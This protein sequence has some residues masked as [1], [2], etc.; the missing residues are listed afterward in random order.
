VN[1]AKKLPAGRAPIQA[2]NVVRELCD[3]LDAAKRGD[4]SYAGSEIRRAVT[5][6]AKL[7]STGAI[8]SHGASLIRSA[9]A[10]A[11]VAMRAVRSGAQVPAA[12]PEL[13]ESQRRIM[14]STMGIALPPDQLRRSEDEP[15]DS[16]LA[17]R[18][19]SARTDFDGEL[20]AEYHGQEF[21]IKRTGAR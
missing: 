21:Y 8:D 10:R 1:G 19:G 7:F 3:S 2:P 13:V 14:Q 4:L 5:L 20:H 12:A 17:R 16:V 9:A 6:G 11:E 18:A 15:F